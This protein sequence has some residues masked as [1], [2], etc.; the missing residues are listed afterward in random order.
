M[1]VKKVTVDFS[2]P[3]LSSLGGLSLVREYERSSN[4]IIKRIEPCI[5]DPR[6]EPMV[7]HSQTEMLRQRIYQIMAGF[8]DVDDCDRLC[9]ERNHEDV[10]RTVCFG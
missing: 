6:W 2:A 10:C 1:A 3:E 7:V 4:R 8:E 9:S 5:K